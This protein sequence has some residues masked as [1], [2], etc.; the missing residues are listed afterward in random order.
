MGMK[1][2]G[3]VMDNKIKTGS[4]VKRV[5]VA[6]EV[7][8]GERQSNSMVEI[9]ELLQNK[10][11]IVVLDANILL[12]IYRSSPDY[13]EFALECLDRIKDYVCIPF[14]VHWEYEKHRKDEYKKKV[15]SIE[16]SAETC[17][18]LV[19]SIG[20]KIKGQCGELSKNGYPDIDE[21]VANLI[22]MVGDLEEQFSS[23]F[24]K[25]Q[26][27]DFLNNWD[28][29]KVLDLVNSFLKMPEPSATFIYKQCREGEYRYKEKTPP[30][31]KDEK[32]DGVSKYGDLLAWA[33]TYEYAASNNKNIIFVTDDVKEDWWE[34]LDDGRILFRKELVKEF[35]RKT[36]IKKD[37]SESLKLIPLV[38][39]DLYQAIA[40]EFMIEAPDAISMIL[41]ATD[42][43]FVDEVQMEV[44]DSVWSE[45][46]YSGTSFLDE[47]NSHV[48]SEGVD[49]WEL[50]DVEFD[51]YE[52]IDVDSGIATY[53]ISYSIKISG[54]SHEYWG[55]DDDTKEIIT[56]PGRRHEC[57]GSIDVLVT[58]ALDTVINWNDDF[59]YQNAEIQKASI[60]EDS[61]EDEDSDFDVYCVECGEKIGYDWES[62]QRDYEGNPMCDD[63]MIT[64]EKGFVC[65]GCGYKYPERMRGGSGTYCINCEEKYDV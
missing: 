21:L 23:Y 19:L 24:I 51:D 12:K 9:K 57:S 39:Y 20:N 64:N 3:E 13:A 1:I 59:E 4:E 65:A 31:Y 11:Y 47:N 60:T 54:V 45:I 33:E 58:R 52:R 8:D 28:E 34:K 30:G 18:Q 5:I 63:C 55:R 41:N 6:S 50:D 43:S 56:S 53:I 35:S 49:E 44:F 25:H 36:K 17:H 37:K 48:G 29:D 2:Q 46:A 40:R 22:E 10:N 26:N 14:N 7:N 62:F 27:L 38:G 42:E 32:K 15:K 61:Y 16:N